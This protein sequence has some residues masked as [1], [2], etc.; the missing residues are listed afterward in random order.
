MFFKHKVLLAASIPMTGI[1][2]Y[3]FLPK[4]NLQRFP[5]FK[6]LSSLLSPVRG[7]R[8]CIMTVVLLWAMSVAR[9][10]KSEYLSS[11]LNVR[12]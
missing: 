11:R 1:V 8:W 12:I 4:T 5:A 10:G 6:I 9:F 3:H 7:A 2:I